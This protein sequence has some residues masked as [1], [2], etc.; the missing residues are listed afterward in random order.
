[1]RR[2]SSILVVKVRRNVSYYKYYE[3]KLYKF[4]KISDRGNIAKGSCDERVSG[5]V[6][7]G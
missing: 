3:N 5:G 6:M 7:N 2:S 4:R 1:M